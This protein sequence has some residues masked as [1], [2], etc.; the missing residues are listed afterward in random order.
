MTR[1]TMPPPLFWDGSVEAAVA[2]GRKMVPY[3]SRA[4]VH[5]PGSH[6]WGGYDHRLNRGVFTVTHPAWARGEEPMVPLSE[7]PRWGAIP[8]INDALPPRWAP[9]PENVA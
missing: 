2:F 9:L 1:R 3:S 4:V 5:M 6:V 7:T 8:G